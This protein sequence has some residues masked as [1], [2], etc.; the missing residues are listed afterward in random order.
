MNNTEF[1]NNFKDAI[2]FVG[3]DQCVC[4]VDH[5]NPAGGHMGPPL[6]ITCYCTGRVRKNIFIDGSA[7]L[8]MT[9]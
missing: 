3:A 7:P 4:P 2:Y 5:C 8:D 6:Q 1:Y 9:G